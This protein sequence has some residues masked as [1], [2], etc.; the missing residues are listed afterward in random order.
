MAIKERKNLKKR[1]KWYES[2][3]NKMVK[4]ELKNKL[5]S[6]SQMK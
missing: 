5:K 1:K 6:S 2:Y 4:K 3:S